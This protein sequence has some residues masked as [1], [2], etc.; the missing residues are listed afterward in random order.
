METINQNIGNVK[1][2]SVYGHT[3]TTGSKAYNLALSKRRS[4]SVSDKLIS[5]GVQSSLIQSTDSL[6]EESPI[7]NGETS[8][9]HYLNRRVEV[10]LKENQPKECR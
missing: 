8:N 5:L 6:G 2:I 3:S 10:I 1:S 7:R 9:D 4:S